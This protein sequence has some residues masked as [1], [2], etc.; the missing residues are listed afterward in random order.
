M[1]N[2]NT[3]DNA[4]ISYARIIKAVCI[5]LPLILILFSETSFAQTENFNFE[6]DENIQN[7]YN[8]SQDSWM[9][10]FFDVVIA[11]TLVLWAAILISSKWRE[12]IWF[13]PAALTLFIV[14]GPPFYF[15]MKDKKAQRFE[16][17]S[18][19]GAAQSS[20]FIE[21]RGRIL[22]NADL[23]SDRVTTA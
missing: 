20:F 9:S 8:K 6:M 2:T 7:E 14:V 5:L 21:S 22:A 11:I 12:R 10:M 13:I 23:I 3:Y 19:S 15:Y 1:Y 16:Q 4:G 18:G 17:S